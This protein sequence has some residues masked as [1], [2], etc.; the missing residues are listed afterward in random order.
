[1]TRFLGTHQTKLDSKG[2]VSVPATFRAALRSLRNHDNGALE[3]SLILRPSHQHPC[4]EAWPESEF[5]TLT[6]ELQRYSEIS[7][8]H[9]DLA[10][11]LFADAYPLESDKEGR[12]IVPEDLLAHANI[13]GPVAFM[14]IGSRFQLWEPRAAIER[15]LAARQRTREQAPAAPGRAMP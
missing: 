2:R 6:A 1:M 15:R 8:Q 13:T 3:V 10:T 14:G 11:A 7:E 9:E 5:D 4:I 12:I